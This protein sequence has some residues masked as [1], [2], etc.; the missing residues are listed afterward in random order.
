MPRN[1]SEHQVPQTHSEAEASE[2]AGGMAF[3]HG[4]SLAKPQH[5][6]VELKVS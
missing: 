4:R 6:L 5:L 3:N 2:P 1:R